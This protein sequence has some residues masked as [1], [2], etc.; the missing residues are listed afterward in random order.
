M[1]RTLKISTYKAADLEISV[2]SLFIY[3]SEI[4]SLIIEH[5]FLSVKIR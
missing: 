4:P 1:M 3:T 2:K 5:K